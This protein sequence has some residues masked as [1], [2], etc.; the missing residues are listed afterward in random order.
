M[1]DNLFQV[2]I[3]GKRNSFDPRARV[4]NYVPALRLLIFV[5]LS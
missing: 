3:T 2:E 5:I 4:Y 1:L